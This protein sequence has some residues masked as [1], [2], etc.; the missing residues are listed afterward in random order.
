MVA[1]MLATLDVLDACLLTLYY[2]MF[3]ATNKIL[4][5]VMSLSLKYILSYIYW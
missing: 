4:L 1:C 2:F 3:Y 5:Y